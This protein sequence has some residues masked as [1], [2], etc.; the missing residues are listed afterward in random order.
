MTNASP[1]RTIKSFV[2]RA[3]RLSPRQKLGLEFYLPKYQLSLEEGVW[4]LSTHFGRQADVVMEIGFGMGQTLV[5]MALDQ[6]HINFIGIEVHQAGIGSL[7][8]ALHDQGIENVRIAPYD[9]IEVLKR[10]IDAHALSGINIFFPDPWPK[11][12]HHKRRLIQAELVHLLTEKLKS[13][14]FIHL[15]TDWQAYAEQMLDILLQESAL[16]ND[17]PHGGFIPRPNTRPL[18][19][20]EQ[21][22]INLGH[23]VWDLRFTRK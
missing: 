8:V 20:F 3:G 19:K 18:T 12:R 13:G 7:A 10:G 6:P 15:A 4:D 9:A 21:R 23:G 1:L 16:M 2:L 5:T 14:G 11:A 22:G 17:D